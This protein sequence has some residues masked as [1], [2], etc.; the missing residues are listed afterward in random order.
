MNILKHVGQHFPGW[1][2]GFLQEV[3]GHSTGLHEI[4]PCWNTIN[5]E[6]VRIYIR[7][8][9]NLTVSR[10]FDCKYYHTC[11]S[12]TVFLPCCT[13][14]MYR[15]VDGT[16]FLTVTFFF[17]FDSSLMLFVLYKHKSLV[18]SK[19]KVY[20]MIT[21]VTWTVKFR[22]WAFNSLT[23]SWRLV[24]CPHVGQF[25]SS[26]GHWDKYPWGPLTILTFWSAP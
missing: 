25:E 20:F 2:T 24:N 4:S 26:P 9:Q 8:I 7:I 13:I 12:I 19:W 14:G 6:M 3:T 11:T 23:D 15:S 21:L 10:W 5:I 17:I 16:R 1:S 18:P 22:I